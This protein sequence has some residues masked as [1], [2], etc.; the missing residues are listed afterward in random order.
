MREEREAQT[1]LGQRVGSSILP[2]SISTW[3]VCEQTL[4]RKKAIFMSGIIGV[5]RMTRP[6]MQ[7]SLSVSERIWLV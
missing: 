6:L 4:H 1:S 3:R 7:T 5:V 2:R